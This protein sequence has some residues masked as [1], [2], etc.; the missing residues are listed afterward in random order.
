MRHPTLFRLMLTTIGAGKFSSNQKRNCV[1]G[2]HNSLMDVCHVL[3]MPIPFTEYCFDLWII[4]EYPFFLRRKKAIEMFYWF[5]M[6]VIE[7]EFWDLYESI[8]NR[9]HHSF[10]LLFLSLDSN[11]KCL[12]SIYIYQ[13]HTTILPHSYINAITKIQKTTKLGNIPR[14]LKWLHLNVKR[15]T[16]QAYTSN[17]PKYDL[18]DQKLWQTKTRTETDT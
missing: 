4:R 2:G 6:W 12:K 7:M 18:W 8:A 17:N 9:W 5:Q 11:I 14:D 10:L 1:E 15:T 3:H 16:K 13:Y